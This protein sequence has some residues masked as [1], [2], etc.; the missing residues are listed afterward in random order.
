MSN[1]ASSESILQSLSDDLANAAA[2]AGESVV[3]IHARKRIPASGVVLAEGVVV[4]AHHTIHREDDIRVSLPDGTR[5][6]ATLAGRDPSTD[7]AVLRLADVT[8]T[9]ARF[10]DADDPRVGQLVLALGRP[11]DAVTASLGVVSA[12][13]G[14]WRTW[15]G[16]RI[17]RFIRLDLSIYDGFSGGA[18]VDA[19]GRVI[20]LNTSGLARSAAIAIPVST[21]RRV[22]EQLL[23]GGRVRRGYLGIGLQTVRLPA[24]LVKARAFGRDVAL[25]VVSVEEDG[26]AARAG[27]TLG[28]V[29]LTFDGAPIGDPGEL[30]ALLSEDR[31]DHPIK[32]QV[33]RGGDVRDVEVIVADRA[34]RSSGRR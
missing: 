7:L 11:G 33:L 19:R 15:H 23:A 14:E 26:P 20:G 30:L 9:P 16:G 13:G 1:A 31:I 3:A 29:L 4:A 17:D 25:L 2:S 6:S 32:L 27:L 12:V 21:V 22:A 8:G 18:L 5:V 10:I 34:Q 28:D 24:S